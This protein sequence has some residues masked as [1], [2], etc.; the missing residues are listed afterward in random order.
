MVVAVAQR[1]SLR[2]QWVLV[3][4]VLSSF[5]EATVGTCHACLAGWLQVQ[6]A[7]PLVCYP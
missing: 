3:V 4:A 5:P 2:P 1:Y 6:G 7:A